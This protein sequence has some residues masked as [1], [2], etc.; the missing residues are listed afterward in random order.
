[1]LG[2]GSL[3]CV[4]AAY[5]SRAGHEVSVLARAERLVELRKRPIRVEGLAE[6]DAP[7]TWASP[8]DAPGGDLL[9]LV[10]KTFQTELALQQLGSRD[11][12]L[13]LS[14]QNG[15]GKDAL[16]ETRFPGRVIGGATQV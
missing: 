1:V 15:V 16:L 4:L 6:F 2:N 7:V 14:L 10:V 8:A 13:A 5:L 11:Y 9:I 3:G 12:R